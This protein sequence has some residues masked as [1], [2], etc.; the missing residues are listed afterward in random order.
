MAGHSHWARIKRK[1]GVTDARRGRLWSKLS[2]YIT[3]A[4]R[5]GVPN[6][7]D[8]LQLRY[9]IDK[10][11]AANMPADTIDRAVKKGAGGLEGASYQDIRYECY[12]PGGVALLVEALTDNPN[13]TA[14]E[15]R[16]ILEKGGGN[17]GSTNCV[18]WQFKKKGVITVNAA[19]ASEDQLMELAL[20]HGA[21][22]VRPDEDVLEIIT[23]PPAFEPVRAALAA[24]KIEPAS[25]ELSMITDN[26]VPVDVETGRRILKL[27]EALEEND[28]VQN[29]YS[30]ADLPE[31]VDA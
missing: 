10:A 7:N 25:A 11:K 20:E 13:R 24:K 12:G 19:D 27:I 9:A 1:K 21:D 28:D 18:A 23:D 15:I 3:V 5:S 14:P 29:V 30:N 6:P 4:A 8:N 2:R 22:D 31:G 26:L 17:L 16:N